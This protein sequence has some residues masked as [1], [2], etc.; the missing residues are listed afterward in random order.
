MLSYPGVPGEQVSRAEARK[1][2]RGEEEHGGEGRGE[3]GESS[4]TAR[5]ADR[6]TDRQNH[7]QYSNC[8]STVMSVHLEPSWNLLQDL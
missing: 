4:L 6:R 3:E 7:S 1:R 8:S 5:Q 2:R